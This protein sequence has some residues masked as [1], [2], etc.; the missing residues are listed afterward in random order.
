MSW[1]SLWLQCRTHQFG[2]WHLYLK[3]DISMFVH[4]YVYDNGTTVYY[5]YW[6]SYIELG[7][8]RYSLSAFVTF[9]WHTSDG[10]SSKGSRK[11][12][13][14]VYQRG[15]S[16]QASWMVTAST[17]FWLWVQTVQP[18]SAGLAQ[19]TC[20]SGTIPRLWTVMDHRVPS[21]LASLFSECQKCHGRMAACH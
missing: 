16:L 8:H 4:V 18:I 21:P 5:F 19:T 3:S 15:K 14:A 7:K 17:S 10:S 12:W 13:G 2:C 1:S 11:C 9:T 20:I 6:R